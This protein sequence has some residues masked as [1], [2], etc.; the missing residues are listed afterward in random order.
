L[1]ATRPVK[2][3]V[4]ALHD[5]PEVCMVGCGRRADRCASALG[6]RIYLCSICEPLRVGQIGEAAT[7]SLVSSPSTA[8]RAS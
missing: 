3:T 8:G 2:V 7:R 1:A 5:S 4:T 6:R